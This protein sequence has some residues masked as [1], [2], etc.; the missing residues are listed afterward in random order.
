MQAF[1]PIKDSKLIASAWWRLRK[2]FG[3]TVT[4]HAKLNLFLKIYG[5]R[6]D[7]F[8]DL[9]SV[10]QSVDL[11]DTLHIEQTDTGGIEIDSSNPDIPVDQSNLVWRAAEILAGEA[12]REV[13][14]LKF[15][16]EKNIPVMAGLAGGSSNGAGAIKGL[17]KLW[18][19]DL[20]DRELF[21]IAAIVGSDV[22]FCLLGGT[23]LVSGRGEKLE[24]MPEGIAADPQKSGAFLLVFPPVSVNT[25]QAYQLLDES[26]EKE[27]GNRDSLEEEY[28]T[29]RG[30][31]MSAIAGGDFPILFH[32][33]FEVPIFRSRPELGAI[34]INL[35]NYAGHAVLSGS[36][37]CMF[38]WY[39]S[40]SEAVT[41]QENYPAIAGEIALIAQPVNNGIEIGN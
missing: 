26:L 30:S 6:P 15:T 32:N 29:I 25:R 20:D 40:M 12:G 9:I 23:A 8:H 2:I 33:D 14:G 11:S 13:G 5:E 36:G 18:D 7:G 37:S 1:V 10:M 3:I 35:R 28:E 41:A 31:W 4:C 16:I 19:L 24:P 17:R 39:P 21:R 27:A 34:H 22:P 38:A